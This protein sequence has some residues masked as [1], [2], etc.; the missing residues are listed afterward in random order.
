MNSL[1]FYFLYFLVLISTARA[2]TVQPEQ[3]IEAGIGEEPVSLSNLLYNDIGIDHSMLTLS[4]GYGRYFDIETIKR[5]LLFFADYGAPLAN[6]DFRNFRLRLGAQ[7]SVFDYKTFRLPIRLSF[8]VVGA[9]NKLFQSIGLGS[10]LGIAPG[11]YGRLF[12]IAPEFSWDQKWGTHIKHSDWYRQYFYE[13]AK[14]GWY[15]M[16][17]SSIRAGIYFAWNINEHVLIGLKAG[18]QRFGQ[19]NVLVPPV[20]GTLHTE[21][22]F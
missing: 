17:S 9:H 22:R 7:S 20:Y 5:R 3:S 12:E 8:N 10:E 18:Y 2:N 14:N 19:Y 16:S 21:F 11:Y 1:K 13:N 15:S 4:L 6:F